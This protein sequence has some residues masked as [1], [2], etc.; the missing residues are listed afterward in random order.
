MDLA[1]KDVGI[2]GIMFSPL[3]MELRDLTAFE[4]LFNGER[5]FLD[6]P[7]NNVVRLLLFD[8]SCRLCRED[9]ANS[10]VDFF[11]GA[12]VSYSTLFSWVCVISPKSMEALC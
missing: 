12:K 3:A 7:F 4:S 6:E 11:A 5:S 8:S 10:S 9:R 2:T 1:L